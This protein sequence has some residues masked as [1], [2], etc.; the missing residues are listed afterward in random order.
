MY[1][2]YA[3]HKEYPYSKDFLVCILPLFRLNMEIYF[4]NVL[5]YILLWYF[6]I[7]LWMT[8]SLQ[9]FFFFVHKCFKILQILIMFTFLSKVSSSLLTLI[10]LKMPF[11]L[12]RKTLWRFFMDAVQLSQGY[13]ATTWTLDSFLHSIKSIVLVIVLCIQNVIRYHWL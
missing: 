9:V 4:V 7:Y 3:L 13:R 1:P 10:E 6:H 12:K 11:N 5:L 2:C 8:L